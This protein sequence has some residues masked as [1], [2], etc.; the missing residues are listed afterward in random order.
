MT[1]DP[2]TYSRILNQ[3][4]MLLGSFWVST[5]S[6]QNFSE[7]VRNLSCGFIIPEAIGREFHK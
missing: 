4:Y 1:V 6:S 3:T 2:C 7:H 5:L